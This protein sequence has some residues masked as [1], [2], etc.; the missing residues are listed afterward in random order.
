MPYSRRQFLQTGGLIAAGLSLAPAMV[1]AMN[2]E[3]T[4]LSN[5][6][7]I[8]SSEISSQNDFAFYAGKW[9]IRVKKLKTRLKNSND[10]VEQEATEEIRPI[11]NGL[12]Y[13]GQFQQTVNGV[14]YEGL[15]I[16]LF[17]PAAKLW[18][19]LWADSNTGK[20][21]PPVVGSFEK[22]N[23]VFYGKDRFDNKPIDVMFRWDLK[24][25]NNPVWSQ[26]FSADSG[27]TWETNCYMYY[28]R[29]IGA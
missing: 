20:L 2:H 10:W 29:L 1:R 22:D 25:R 21:D 15:A 16:H 18:S 13:I 4:N 23:G 17:D 26:A 19:N 3:S 6:L 7:K 14:H 28:S 8:V 11:L 9:K 24:D 27:K 5:D 12:G